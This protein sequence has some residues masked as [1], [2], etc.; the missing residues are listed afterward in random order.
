MPKP[1]HTLSVIADADGQISIHAD[2][3]GLAVL[4]ATLERLKRNIEAGSCEHDHLFSEAWGGHELSETM[5]CEEKGYVIHHVKV[6]GWTEE[7]AL[8][9]GFRNEK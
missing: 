9:H 5:G 6:Y 2:A 7:W 1:E 4:I 8:K 3:E